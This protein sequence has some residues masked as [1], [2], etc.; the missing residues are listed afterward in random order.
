[1]RVGIFGAG[2]AG[3]MA[4]RWLPP[5]QELICYID[6]NGEKQGKIFSGIPVCSLK[7]ALKADLDLILIAVINK[8]SA[9]TIAEQIR[10]EG[11]KGSM[12]DLKEIRKIQDIR[13][14]SLRLAAAEIR[15]REIPGELAEL[16]VFQG[17]FASEMNRLLPDRK[18]YLFDTFDGFDQRDLEIEAAVSGSG[19]CLQKKGYFCDTSVEKVR[20]SLEHPTQAVFCKGYFPESAAMLPEPLPHFALV[21]LDPDLYEPVY[22]GLK[23]FYPL[24]NPGGVILIHDYNSLQFP[25]VKKAVREFCEER[26]LFIV[27]LMDLHGSAVL[28]K[29]GDTI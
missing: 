16:G 10:L 11:Y 24:L 25:S 7:Q 4:A 9:K 14:A 29:Q 6:N 27:P 13:T 8:D 23:F 19:K 18:L 28:I 26:S 5:E 17:R 22:Q 20:E 2:Q 21:S 3:I 15:R 1:M 12:S